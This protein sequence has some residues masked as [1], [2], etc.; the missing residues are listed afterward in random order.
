MKCVNCNVWIF[1]SVRGRKKKKVQRDTLRAA[2]KLLR[3]TL[4]MER[5]GAYI[6]PS[7]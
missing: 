3:G 7:L 2:Q 4:T 5:T 6:I 1:A